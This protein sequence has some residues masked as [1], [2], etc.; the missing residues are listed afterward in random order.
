MDAAGDKLMQELREVVAAAEELLGATAAEGSEQVQEMRA[1]AEETL[2]KARASIEGAGKDVE[3][4]IRAHPFAAVGI[5]AAAGL[6][7]GVLLARR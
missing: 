3:E 1:R 4:Q 2:R 7:L 6:I 5:A